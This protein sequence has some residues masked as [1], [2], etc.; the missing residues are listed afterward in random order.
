MKKRFLVLLKCV[1]LLS[2][3][4]EIAWPNLNQ[5]WRYWTAADGLEEMHILWINVEPSGNVW[6][7]QGRVEETCFLDGYAISSI[8][9][10]DP[11]G[12]HLPIRESR[13]GQIWSGTYTSRAATEYY[14]TGLQ[15]YL[16]EERRWITYEIDE[17]KSAS[18]SIGDDPFSFFPVAENRAFFLLSDVLMEFD[19]TTKKARVIK[20]VDE[21]N[22]ERFN[23]MIRTRDGSLWIACEKG[24]LKLDGQIDVLDLTS[25]WIEYPFDYHLGIHNLRY[26]FEGDNGELYGTAVTV[27]GEKDAVVRFKAG[28][29]ETLRVADD[30]NV[31]GIPGAENSL[32]VL[33]GQ[34]IYYEFFDPSLL[35]IEDGRK[36]V[37]LGLRALS[38]PIM[39]PG[40]AVQPKGVFWLGSLY[41]RGATRY[42]PP[43]WRTPPQIADIHESCV[44]IHEDGEGRIW[45]VCRRTL[46]LLENGEWKRYPMPADAYEGLAHLRDGRIAVSCSGSG[47]IFDPE[48]KVFEPVE[49]PQGRWFEFKGS[50]KDG[51][52]WVSS[53]D[54]DTVYLETY[55]GRSFE[56]IVEREGDWGEVQS[57]TGLMTTDDGTIW[58][59]GVGFYGLARYS[60]GIY[61]TFDS[62]DGFPGGSAGGG[63][64]FLDMG[65]GK[66]W[67]GGRNCIYE[68]DGETFSLIKQ[69]VEAIWSMIKSRD[70]SIWIG[71]AAGVSRFK[72]GSWVTNSAED[73]LPDATVRQIFEDSQGRI[74]V[75]TFR[76]ISLYHPDADDDTP[77]TWMQAGKN[78]EEIGPSGEAQF[79]FAGIDKWKYTEEHRLIYS[80]RTD[81]GDWSPFVS[82]TVASV[83]GLTAGLHR[84]E[85]RAMD[86]NW[87]IDPEP[88]VWEFV[89]LLPWYREPVFLILASIGTLLILLFA[90]LAYSR[91]R[92]VI[93]SNVHLRH[94]T[95][96][97]RETTDELQASNEELQTAN[98]RLLELD[99]MKSSF[100]SQASHDLRTPLTAIKSSMDNLI[101]G[102]G[103]GLN[104]KQ[105]KV[106]NRALR[107]V[108]RLTH[109]INDVLDVNR[110]ESGRM[111]LEK[112]KVPF[113]KLVQDAVNENRPAAEQK[114]IM[115]QA[116]GLDTSCSMELDAGK[117]ERVVGELVS[118][119]IKY[120]PEGGNVEVV[121][122]KE[123]DTIVL[124]VKD[125][126]IGM[127]PE[128]CEKI[129]ERFFRTKASQKMAKGSG[130]G[131][132]IA[133]ELVE[134][135]GGTLSV[136]SEQGRGSTF[137]MSLPA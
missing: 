101:R 133:K 94:T 82:D 131:L 132:S 112:S 111:I 5:H 74:W 106:L 123:D 41:A 17:I 98:E 85:V 23:R 9:N 19:A 91:H 117:M 77:E 32:W 113:E 80:Y 69:K 61:Q 47:V 36:E 100:V 18:P 51:K 42:A 12:N 75:R 28:V 108:E 105:E 29:W 95:D 55:D 93:H 110:I 137:T 45:F 38:A 130:L 6:I 13:S 66:I 97:L 14:R 31:I 92:Q 70:G 87:N 24:A 109:L 54:E 65:D 37:V 118:N 76:G 27:T 33:Q 3:F 15:Q 44:D 16:R 57:L 56:T 50:R 53:R 35:R 49:H 39:V 124:S 43:T 84:F 40:I 58:L 129:F 62:S 11:S 122:G 121:L 114:R 120:T 8:P 96:E 68:F 2:L 127:T 90:G 116:S 64:C 125:S 71:S 21:T 59:G 1:A 136:E 89:V 7:S 88:A 107:S 126:G 103:G 26:L 86:R 135:H 10:P 30:E 72:D 128:E 73:G 20:S 99:K 25:E 134:M 78:A 81:D 4:S 52:V 102:I 67:L 46:V 119:A 60:N 63:Y 34:R 22:L 104:E 48:T 115:L 79:A 83:T